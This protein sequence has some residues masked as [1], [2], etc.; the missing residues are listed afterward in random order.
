M[1]V[2]TATTRLARELRAEYDREQMAAG[3][4]SWPTANILPWAA[5][6]SELWDSWLFSGQGAEVLHLLRPSEEQAIWENI[7]SS[8]EGSELLQVSPTATAALD[9]WNLLSEWN[10]SMDASEWSDS[11]DSEAF[12]QWALE[13]QLRCQENAWVSDAQLAGF[14]VDR[15][16]EGTVSVP[17][18]IELAGFLELTPVQER[19]LA[20]LSGRG[21]QVAVR[22]PCRDKGVAV[23]L[24]LIDRDAEIRAASEWAR[25]SLENKTATGAT[26][27]S[28]GIVV[29]DLAEC[30]SRVERIFAEQFHPR[31]R[32]RPDLDAGRL[33]NISL[34]TPVGEYPIMEAAFLILGADPQSMPIESVGRLLR[35]PFI[36]GAH[37]LDAPR[38]GDATDGAGP[39]GNEWTARAL[40]DGALRSLKE[41]EVSAADILR[42]AKTP[43]VAYHCPQMA[44]L[45]SMWVEAR[46]VLEP[47]QMPSDWATALSALLA[48]FGWPG[49]GHLN[50]AEFQTM[51]VWNE[52]LS[53]LA[54]LD[55]V[56]GVMALQAAVGTLHRLAASRQFQPESG[57]A[58]VQILGVFEASGLRFDRLWMMGMHDGSWPAS[59]GPDPFLPFRLQRR[60]NLPRSTPARELAFTRLL[61][62]RLLA[63]SP[64]VVVS[65]PERENDADL[66]VSPLFSSLPEAQIADLGISGSG[67]YLEE[68][69]GA[70]RMEF[71]EDHAGSSFRG[72]SLS[73]GTSLFKYQ[74]ACPFRAFGQ[75]RLGGRAS[76]GAETGLSALDRGILI[77]DVLDRI[78]E[79]L[80]SH[81]S[82]LSTSPGQLA[83]LARLTVGAA[84]H[85]MSMRRRA[86]RKSRFAAIEQE[87]LEQ[88]VTEWFEIESQ[89]QSFVVLHQEEKRRVN[90]GGIEVQIRADRVDQLEDGSLVIV[91]Y[92]SGDHGPSRWE[93]ERPDDP[94]LPIYATT[95]T[96]RVAGVFFGNLK[97]GKVGFRGLAVSEDIV[98]GVKP[99]RQGPELGERIDDWRE[100]LNRLA[101]AF[102]E[103]K[104]TVDPKDRKLTCRLCPLPTFCRVSEGKRWQTGGGDPEDVDD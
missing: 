61:T 96:S 54:G 27:I 42:M 64:T 57:P 39:A 81:Q 103:G 21:V 51:K 58:P 90:V 70:S 33:F 68:L 72:S 34:G 5:W 40:L 49:E 26:E 16:G 71:L 10:L 87:R 92:K 55:S 63:S 9:S 99:P 80:S 82:L 8:G 95:A 85:D 24:G 52:L 43:N 102:Q 101:T 29:P 69:W 93:G 19:L 88:L 48:A 73:G 18:G 98:P 28:V 13:F 41:P 14:M 97:T 65:Y 35:S 50:S 56:T 67:N 2:I 94:Q 45:L 91:D 104:A 47:S 79:E 20:A 77:H 22:E 59:S 46:K 15:I 23:R 62:D 4:S 74:A 37:A 6:L 12:Y 32:L 17:D 3:L 100:V 11:T 83:A 75:L 38:T 89:R 84:I 60:L 25:Y 86:L 66:R 78:W 1:T 44:W 36:S 30:R 7:V 31:S 76:E 53:E